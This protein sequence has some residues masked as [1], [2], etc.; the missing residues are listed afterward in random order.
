MVTPMDYEAKAKA[1]FAQHFNCA[2]SVFAPFAEEADID[3][4]TA[5]KLATPFG[6]GMGHAGRVCGA[7]SGALMVI[8]LF[9]GIEVYD[10]E[11]KEACYELTRE[12]QARFIERH[13]HINCPDLLGLDIGDPSQLQLAREQALFQKVC[14]QFVGGAVRILQ[15]LL[16]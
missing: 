8:G 1:Y 16:G 12:F 14:P 11:K 2:Q 3:L 5:L 9:K 10:K 7:V 13:G 15:E 4:G 6:G